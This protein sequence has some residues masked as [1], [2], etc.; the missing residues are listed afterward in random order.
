MSKFGR[1]SLLPF[2][3]RMV[4]EGRAERTEENRRGEAIPCLAIWFGGRVLGGW[5]V[6][7]LRRVKYL[8]VSPAGVWSHSSVN[9]LV[10][11][12]SHVEPPFFFWLVE[13]SLEGA[14]DCY[15]TCSGLIVR[16]KHLRC[17]NKLLCFIIRSKKARW[18]RWSSLELHSVHSFPPLTTGI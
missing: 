7:Y 11:C 8:K 3:L 6:I 10:G 16:S 17:S 13:L 15:R 9:P 18:K 5:L 4:E 12:R 14:L 1:V 2:D